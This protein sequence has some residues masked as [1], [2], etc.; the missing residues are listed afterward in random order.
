[1]KDIIINAMFGVLG[2]LTWFVLWMLIH[3]FAR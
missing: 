2:T 1:M 3:D